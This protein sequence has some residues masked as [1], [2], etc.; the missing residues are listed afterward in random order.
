MKVR[1]IAAVIVCSAA[2][3]VIGVPG[4]NAYS[5]NT[6]V[7]WGVAY[8]NCSNCSALIG[9]ASW[10]HTQASPVDL[11]LISGNCDTYGPAAGLAWMASSPYD[12]GSVWWAEAA[13]SVPSAYCSGVG[14]RLTFSQ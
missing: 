10:A 12:D 14:Y 13:V 5:S 11:S 4:V 8:T 2:A 6:N 3:L 7:Y 9:V 1:K